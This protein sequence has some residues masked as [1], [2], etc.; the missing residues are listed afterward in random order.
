MSRVDGLC[1]KGTSAYIVDSQGPI[2]GTR[3]GA[4]GGSVYT[5]DWTNPCGCGTSGSCTT[6]SATWSP[7]VT[8]TFKLSAT[9][10]SI[11]DGGGNDQYFRNSGIAVTE[12][13]L[14]AVN[15]VHPLGG[16]LSGAY[17]KSLVKV[18]LDDSGTA[19]AT[20]DSKWSFTASTLGHDVDM[21][22]L[23]CGP[24][25]CKDYIYIGDEYNYVY[26]LNLNTASPAAAVEYEYNLRSIVGAVRDDKGIES[27]AYA[28]STGYFYA[29]IQDTATVHVISLSNS[30]GNGVTT[31]DFASNSAPATNAPADET[32]KATTKTPTTKAMVAASGN[33]EACWAVLMYCGMVSLQV[34]QC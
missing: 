15:G 33:T 6:S 19:S 27:L 9:A 17:P 13:A 11:N 24:D 28:A 12:D 18:S 34:G 16:S 8:A 23:A 14:F 22:G 21:E 31:S 3:V 32:T 20:A 25:G 29:G 2:Y 7:T 1:I 10:S 5:V 30:S 4:L 26:K